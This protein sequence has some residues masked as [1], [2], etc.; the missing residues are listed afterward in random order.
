VRAGAAAVAA[1]LVLAGC[2]GGD[3]GAA[4]RDYAAKAA[5]ICR[6][7]NQALGRLARRTATAQRAGDPAKVFARLAELTRDAQ[8][9]SLRAL[10]RIDALEVPGA[11]RDRLKQWI[12]DSRREQVLVGQLAD[13]FA[14]QDRTRVGTLSEQVDALAQRTTAFARAYG[15]GACGVRPG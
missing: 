10:D 13:A 1:L 12:A 7:S 11:D 2:G 5:A 15:M 14:R 3:N 4:R 6:S 8:R 9:T